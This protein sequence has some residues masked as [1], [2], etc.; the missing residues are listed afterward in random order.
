MQRGGIA[1]GIWISW[2]DGE[3]LDYSEPITRIQMEEFTQFGY[4][5]GD[6]NFFFR[7]IRPT[8]TIDY[9]PTFKLLNL[10]G[11]RWEIVPSNLQKRTWLHSSFRAWFPL[12]RRRTGA[13]VRMVWV[14]ATTVKKRLNPRWCPKSFME[15]QKFQCRH[16]LRSWLGWI[17]VIP[18]VQMV[19]LF[20]TKCLPYHFHNFNLIPIGNRD[21][22]RSWRN[23]PIQDLHGDAR[24]RSRWGWVRQSTTAVPALCNSHMSVKEELWEWSGLRGF[25]S[26]GESDIIPIIDGS[27][28]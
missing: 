2:A 23:G 1:N 16:L 13:R 20:I 28:C 27:F 10:F 14:Q 22:W 7:K 18:R 24:F 17:S 25:V 15:R 9:E 3:P 21:L 26:Q 6:I 4:N 11:C 12:I 8:L 5:Q 19:R